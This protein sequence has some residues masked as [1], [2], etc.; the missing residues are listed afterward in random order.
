MTVDGSGVVT[1]SPDTSYPR[2]YYRLPVL[3]LEFDLQELVPGAPDSRVH[4]LRT[5]LSIDQ[6]GMNVNGCPN[7]E[8]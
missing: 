3:S 2:E 5:A 1:W 8:G 7:S 6:M 4:A